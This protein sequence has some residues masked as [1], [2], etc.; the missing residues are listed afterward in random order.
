MSQ[1]TQYEWLKEKEYQKTFDEEPEEVCGEDGSCP[2]GRRS[3]HG[4][5]YNR[6]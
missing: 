3:C 1:Q 5:C 6:K 4:C 2:L